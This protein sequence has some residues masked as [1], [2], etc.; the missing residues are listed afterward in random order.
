MI[1]RGLLFRSNFIYLVEQTKIDRFID[2]IV[3]IEVALSFVTIDRLCLIELSIDSKF[4][5]G[6]KYAQLQIHSSD[7]N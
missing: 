7:E 3:V 2:S 4:R 1:D 5:L 6:Y